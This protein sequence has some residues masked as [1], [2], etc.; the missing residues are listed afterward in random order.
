MNTIKKVWLTDHGAGMHMLSLESSD[1]T[2]DFPDHRSMR[3]PKEPS[4][5]HPLR[6]T[7]CVGLFD[8]DDLVMIR[9]S[10]DRTLEEWDDE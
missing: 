9:D 8:Y 7:V 5:E 2:S 3:F 10:I 4:E 6:R 1:P